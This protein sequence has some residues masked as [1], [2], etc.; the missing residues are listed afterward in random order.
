MKVNL[1]KDQAHIRAHRYGNLDHIAEMEEKSGLM[2]KRSNLTKPD[3]PSSSISTFPKES[4]FGDFSAQH[5]QESGSFLT[6]KKIFKTQ[7]HKPFA[8][9]SQKSFNKDGRGA[10]NPHLHKFY[11]K[12]QNLSSS[13]KKNVKIEDEL[14]QD[15]Q[16]SCEQE[17][18]AGV[19]ISSMFET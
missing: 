16:D 18:N 13:F 7:Y 10:S 15:D 17:K 11:L 2:A 3:S 9:Y 1:C 4:Q 5:Q 19:N 6:N 14:A 8:L 12:T